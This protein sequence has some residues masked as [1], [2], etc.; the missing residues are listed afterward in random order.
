[1]KLTK[2]GIDFDNTIVN[3][4]K[5]FGELAL[6][7]NLITKSIS[8]KKESVKE[9]FVRNNREHLWTRLQGEVYGKQIFRAKPYKHFKKSISKFEG[10]LFKKYIIS[11]KTKHPILGKRFNLHKAALKWIELNDFYNDKV[12]FKIQNIY[13]ENTIKQKLK[14]IKTLKCNIFIDDM[15][16]IL[17]NLPSK[18]NR[19]LFDPNY[20]EK[21][22]YKYKII[23]SWKDLEKFL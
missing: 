9:Y 20:I 2:I 21:K 6:S 10:N 12:N 19:I 5:L 15:S 18:I 22:T 14:K 1:M 13:F 23:N 7:K 8:L 3:Y 17:E 4:D 16:I 11:H